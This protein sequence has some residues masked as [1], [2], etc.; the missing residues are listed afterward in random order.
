[1]E[2]QTP[3]PQGGSHK[4]MKLCVTAD[5]RTEHGEGGGIQ[6]RC[7]STECPGNYKSLLNKT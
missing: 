1:M 2:R 4:T 5:R 7:F 3:G 6:L